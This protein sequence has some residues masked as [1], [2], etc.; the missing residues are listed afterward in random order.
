MNRSESGS[1]VVVLYELSNRA[2]A[3]AKQR[4]L[5][6]GNDLR[7]FGSNGKAR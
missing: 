3:A 1:F 2:N 7:A 5:P 4:E 6:D